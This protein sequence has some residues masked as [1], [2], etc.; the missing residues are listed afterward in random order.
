MHDLGQYLNQDSLLHSLDPRVKIL[1]VVALSLLILHINWPGLLLIAALILGLCFLGK[2]SPLFLFRS[3][4]AVWPFF[5]VLFLVY[6]LFTP[7]SPVLFTFHMINISY[8]GIYLGFG[9]LLRFL[10]LVLAASLL[11]MTTG[12]VEITRALEHLLRPLKVFRVSS[13]NIALM[14]GLALRFIPTLQQELSQIGEAGK[15]RGLDLKSI[16]LLG[17]AKVMMQL[18]NPLTINLLARSEELAQAMEARAYQNGPRT[19]MNELSFRKDDY[20]AL[21]IIIC[22]ALS[23]LLFSLSSA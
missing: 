8:P 17:R 4:R 20:L 6:V 21:G 14:I 23:I 19:Y 11:T 7:G 2:I 13:H 9:Q 18:G 15:A 12:H 3:S 10:L 22:M 5:A 1:A 16:S